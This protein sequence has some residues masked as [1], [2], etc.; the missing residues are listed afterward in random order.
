MLLEKRAP[1]VVEQGTV[2]LNRVQNRLSR[3]AILL[4][5][6]DRAFEEVEPH[7][8]RFAPLPC[9][10]NIA[11]RMSLQE[12]PDVAVKQLV[13]HAEPV[14]RIEHLLGEEEAVFAVEVASGA[15]GLG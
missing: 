15:G 5:V 7:Q 6:H 9:D 11:G 14:A 2:R 3:F 8:G 4:H 12:L 1:V 13:R 10:V